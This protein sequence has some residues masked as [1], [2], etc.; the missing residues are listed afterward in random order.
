MLLAQYLLLH[1]DEICVPI[2]LKIFHFDGSIFLP[3]LN[4]STIVAV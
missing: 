2:A 1:E 3:Y 4:Y